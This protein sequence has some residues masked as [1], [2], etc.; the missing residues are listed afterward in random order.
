MFTRLPSLFAGLFASSLLLLVPACGGGGIGPDTREPYRSLLLVGDGL[1]NRSTVLT[2]PGVAR[3]DSA[4]VPA[5]NGVPE[6]MLCDDANDTT[7]GRDIDGRCYTVVDGK[8]ACLVTTGYSRYDTRLGSFS[9]RLVNNQ[10]VAETL[11]L[12]GF[13]F[14]VRI[15]DGAGNE[16]WNMLDDH[17]DL[18]DAIA[19]V[20]YRDMAKA[21]CASTVVSEGSISANGSTVTTEP[22]SFFTP[23][24]YFVDKTTPYRLEAGTIYSMTVSWDGRDS[25]GNTVAPGTYTVYTDILVRNAVTGLAWPTPEPTL[26]TIQAAPTPAN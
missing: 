17:G 19:E 23:T 12:E 22:F 25:N 10:S 18:R 1:G 8:E 3:P 21:G 13:G 7:N 6:S 24:T 9:V 5:Y 15:Q 16:V 26:L 4:A 2:L 11:L 14:N 20:G